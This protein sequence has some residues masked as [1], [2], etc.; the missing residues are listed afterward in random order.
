[1]ALVKFRECTAERLSKALCFTNRGIAGVGRSTYALPIALAAFLP[2][3]SLLG[4]ADF[5]QANTRSAQHPTLTKLLEKCDPI[6]ASHGL[7]NHDIYK[8]VWRRFDNSVGE[9]F[10]VDVKS[11]VPASRGGATATVYVTSPGA[12]FDTSR[13]RG[14]YFNCRGQYNDIRSG[15]TMEDAPPR[16]MIGVIATYVCSD[17]QPRRRV[18]AIRNAHIE[19]EQHESVVHPRPSDYCKGF[20]A[21]ACQ[22]IEAGVEAETSPDYCGPGPANIGGDPDPEQR[23]TCDVRY[24]AETV[25]ENPNGTASTGRGL[26]PRGMTYGTITGARLTPADRSPAPF[27]DAWFPVVSVSLQG[28]PMHPPAAGNVPKYAY[29]ARGICMAETRQNVSKMAQAGIRGRF[30]CMYHG[31]PDRELAAAPK[32]NF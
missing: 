28:E 17:A 19:A 29:R 27:V 32:E 23:R 13:L 7:C 1:M 21:D 18:I 15:V 6:T 8:P 31:E 10:K 20:S 2:I 5:A 16:S 12:P 24:G 11:I 22:R 26:M 4:V 3:F 9:I 25:V 14:Y 30:L